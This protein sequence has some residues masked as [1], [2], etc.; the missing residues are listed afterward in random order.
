LIVTLLSVVPLHAEDNSNYADCDI[1]HGG[2]HYGPKEAKEILGQECFDLLVQLTDRS[3]TIKLDFDGV[4]ENGS[5]EDPDTEYELKV[6]GVDPF[7]IKDLRDGSIIL[8]SSQTKDL[9]QASTFNS[10]WP[11]IYLYAAKSDEIDLKD[12]MDVAWEK[13]EMSAVYHW[14][15]SEDESMEWEALLRGRI[16]KMLALM[17]EK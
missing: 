2:I 8:I 6:W 16:M 17:V 5:R 4:L 7:Y 9:G 11:E 10:W 15:I 12:A 13:M 3:K 14:V 1:C